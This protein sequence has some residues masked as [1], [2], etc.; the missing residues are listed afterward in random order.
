LLDQKG[1]KNRKMPFFTALKH[2][3]N[4]MMVLKEKKYLT[5]LSNFNNFDNK[6]FIFFIK[7]LFFDVFILINNLDIKINFI[8][9]NITKI[10]I[11]NI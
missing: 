3:L 2:N 11:K 9:Y 6:N 10:I 5:F 7:F 1:K 4:N 8:K